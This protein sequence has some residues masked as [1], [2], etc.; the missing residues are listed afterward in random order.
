MP[1]PRISMD[2]V[3]EL[4]F[5]SPLVQLH[6]GHSRA[7]E[8]IITERTCFLRRKSGT[9][10]NKEEEK[11]KK[12]PQSHGKL[13]EGFWVDGRGGADIPRKRSDKAPLF[14]PPSVHQRVSIVPTPQATTA[15][16]ANAA[17]RLEPRRQMRPN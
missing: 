1:P 4:M 3:G 2:S 10:Q 11:T 17:P 8:V 13:G 12:L 6:E 14:S 16:S 15:I 7:S 5:S 9:S